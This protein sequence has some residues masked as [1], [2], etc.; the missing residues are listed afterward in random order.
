MEVRSQIFDTHF[1]FFLEIVFVH[2][3]VMTNLIFFIQLNVNS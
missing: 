2:K 3:F 1:K